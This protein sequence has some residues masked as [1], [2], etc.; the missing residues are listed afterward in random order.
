[1]EH[2]YHARTLGTTS[3]NLLIITSNLCRRFLPR[4]WIVM[5]NRVCEIVWLS[6]SDLVHLTPEE[7]QNPDKLV[8]YLEKVCC[9]P[10]NSRETQITAVGLPCA[11]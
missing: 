8:K 9:H 5:S 3:Q 11:Y 4:D 7:V 1:M 2:C 10:R 6:I